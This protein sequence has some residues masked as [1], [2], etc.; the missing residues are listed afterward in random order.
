MKRIICIPIVVFLLVLLLTLCYSK[1][2]IHA[3]LSKSSIG[4][5]E[6][7][8][9]TI[10][11]DGEIYSSTGSESPIEPDE[12]IIMN[13]TSVVKGIELPSKEGEINF[14]AP[15]AKYAKINDYEQYVVVLMNLEWI[16]FDKRILDLKQFERAMKD[17]GYNIEVIDTEQDFIPTTRKRIILDN[18]VIDIYL[19]GSNNEM[20]EEAKHID[21]GGCSYTNL[22]K[23]VNVSWVSFPHFY[24]KGSLIVQYIGED[25]VIMSDLKDILGEQFAGY[26][27]PK[28][29]VSL[30]VN[31]EQ[32][33]YYFEPNVSIIEGTL[34]TRLH[35][36]PPNFG[37][38]PANDEEEYP[39]ILLLDDPINV[40][41]IETDIINSSISNVSEIQL[42]LKGSSY[43]DIANQ[44]KD[45]HIKV[46]GTLFS[47]FTGHHHTKVLMVVDDVLE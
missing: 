6:K 33:E 32:S 31:L 46:Q 42:V 22:T 20:E 9:L 18:D 7:E 15:D 43:I 4:D 8:Q 39:F 37:E 12:S 30:D 35:Y 41:A 13:V 11:V 24:K 25:E 2:N 10:M 14:P 28:F 17:R 47:A 36:G 26:S 34:I 16:R 27:E 21:S 45:K 44:Y 40:I 23:S 38:D 5:V 19:F 3:F 1:E 29:P